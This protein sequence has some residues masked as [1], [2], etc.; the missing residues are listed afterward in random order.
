MGSL[1]SNKWGVKYLLGVIDVF[2]N[3]TWVRPLTNKKA[4][5]AFNGFIGLVN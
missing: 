1:S 5:T 2:T 3:Y 4:A